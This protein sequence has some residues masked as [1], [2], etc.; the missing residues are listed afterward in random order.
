ME[1]YFD[2]L[3]DKGVYTNKTASRDECH[4]K[5]L[6]HRAVVLH[7]INSKGLILL[8][9]RSSNKK[10]WPN[11]WDITAGGHVLAG[12]LGFQALIRESN[13]EIGLDIN[14]KDL[15]FI[16]SA[17]STNIQ[18][19]IIN[20]H[21]NEYYVFDSQNDIDITKLKLQPEEVQD[22]RWFDRA[23]VEK[24]IGDGYKEITDKIE[25]WKM[26]LRYLDM[27]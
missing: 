10:M 3:D 2:I 20:N 25:C 22:I 23:E 14:K 8:Q 16:G 27:K 11:M 24:M 17:L 12:E 7:I 18:G 5:G 26:L 4:N 21:M 19:D 15:L 6:W 1:E 13:E 9:K